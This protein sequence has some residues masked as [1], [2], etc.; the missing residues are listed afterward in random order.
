M[1]PQ[2]TPH[3][4]ELPVE[5]STPLSPKGSSNV[6]LIIIVVLLV[7]ILMGVIAVGMFVV[8]KKSG[9]S[10]S[11][12]TPTTEVV[13]QQ[14]SPT[15]SQTKPSA[16]PTINPHSKLF[17]SKKL[18]IQF[19]YKAD[20]YGDGDTVEV[21]ETGNK[22]YVYASTM[23]P[24]TGQYVEVF[25]KDANDSM[26]TAIKK[27]FLT[28]YSEKDCWVET[29]PGNKAT[30]TYPKPS[31]PNEP[32]FANES[33]CPAGYSKSNGLSYFLTDPTHPTILLFFSIGQ[34]ALDSGIEGKPWQDTI[35]FRD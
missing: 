4:D 26:E 17:T 3:T 5:N 19:L 18:G 9:E 11:T 29:M 15:T 16:T 33:T 13:D 14:Q 27:Q 32:W 10:V 12:V 31:D 30:I 8:G 21:S 25:S 7:L 35:I 1:E 2:Q 22:V 24:T 28:K 20:A 23:K 34:Y 6:L